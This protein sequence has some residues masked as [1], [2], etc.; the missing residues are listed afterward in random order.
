MNWPER[1]QTPNSSFQ[2]ACVGMMNS[3]SDPVQRIKLLEGLERL[4]P[5]TGLDVVHELYEPLSERC[6]HANLARE[7]HDDAELRV[8][9]GG[10]LADRQVTPDAT[11]GFRRTPVVRDE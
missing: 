10:T 11:V 1:G 7:R 4:R 5:H 3:E 6:R 8:H 2:R 9:L